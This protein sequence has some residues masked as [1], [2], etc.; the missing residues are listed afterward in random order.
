MFSYGI[1]LTVLFNLS[2]KDYKTVIKIINKDLPKLERPKYADSQV[3][4]TIERNCKC[5]IHWFISRFGKIRCCLNKNPKNRNRF[6]CYRD[7]FEARV[8]QVNLLKTRPK[9]I[10]MLYRLFFILA[11]NRVRRFKTTRN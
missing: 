4:E 8:A 7:F 10:D 6:F 3:Y 11:K 1:L 2:M 9:V 5:R